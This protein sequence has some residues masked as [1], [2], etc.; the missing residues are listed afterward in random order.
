MKEQMR[1]KVS[2]IHQSE[3][4]CKAISKAPANHRDIN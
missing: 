4:G 1:K 2:E 3:K